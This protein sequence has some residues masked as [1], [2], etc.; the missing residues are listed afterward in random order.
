[1]N[2]LSVV[3]LSS[4]FQ[5]INEASKLDR[6]KPRRHNLACVRPVQTLK[7]AAYTE[8]TY[9]GWQKTAAVFLWAE[10]LS[11]APQQAR[12]ALL[13]L[14]SFRNNESSSEWV[15]TEPHIVEKM[16]EEHRMSR[17]PATK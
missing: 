9:E 7:S 4:V 6:V 11:A 3:W 8:G 15:A 1:M 14:K 2:Q 5:F 10:D 17:A 16:D 13:P 12:L